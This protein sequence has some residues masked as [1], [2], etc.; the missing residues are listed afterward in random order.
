MC[1]LQ[2]SFLKARAFCIMSYLL[3]EI[4]YR[5]SY[6]FFLILTPTQKIRII[7]F[8]CHLFSDNVHTVN[9]LTDYRWTHVRDEP[10]L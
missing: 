5:R 1:E 10:N 4:Q 6:I 9:L 7:Q 2:N 8:T 3:H